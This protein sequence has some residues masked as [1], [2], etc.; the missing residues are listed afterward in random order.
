MTKNYL[1]SLNTENIWIDDNSV[2]KCHNCR[3]SFSLFNRR[4][5]CRLCGKIYCYTCSNFH[6]YTNLKTKLI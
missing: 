4:H 3:D 6:V 5:H 2:S 1:K